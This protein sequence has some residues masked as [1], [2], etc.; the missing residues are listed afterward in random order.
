MAELLVT[1]DRLAHARGTI[2]DAKNCGYGPVQS[3]R[4]VAGG[5]LTKI[6]ARKRE[7]SITPSTPQS[8]AGAVAA[9]LPP[10]EDN[11]E[12]QESE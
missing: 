4:L 10:E 2:L 7:T 9:P 3:E 11:S 5:H 1:S 12:T 8:P 6:E